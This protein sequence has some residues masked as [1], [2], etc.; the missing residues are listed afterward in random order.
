[1]PGTKYHQWHHTGK[2]SLFTFEAGQNEREE[3]GFDDQLCKVLIV[4]GNLTESWEHVALIGKRGSGRER[5]A[6]S[7]NLRKWKKESA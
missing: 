1:M 6:E 3:L 5:D 2:G 4:F 7:E